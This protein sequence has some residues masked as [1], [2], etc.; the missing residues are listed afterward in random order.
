MFNNFNF[1][2]ICYKDSKRILTNFEKNEY[3]TE[4]TLVIKSNLSK[5]NNY[6][7]FRAIGNVAEKASMICRN[8]NQVSVVGE[9]TTSEFI[10]RTN[11]EMKVKINFMVTDLMLI[12]KPTKYKV[13][14]D[15]YTKIVELA[16]VDEYKPEGK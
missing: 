5:K 1:I 16:V 14:K 10:D 4:F 12:T 11:A 6:I 15:K 7:T 2:G 3:Y 8:G 9:V 13:P